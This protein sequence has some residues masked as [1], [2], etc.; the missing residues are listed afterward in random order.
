LFRENETSF[1]FESKQSTDALPVVNWEMAYAVNEQTN[2]TYL[3][4]YV[5]RIVRFS[6]G[7]FSLSAE[8]LSNNCLPSEGK[9][10]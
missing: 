9:S 10:I 3:G 7:S 5:K 2:L 1:I 8:N 4:K 6:A